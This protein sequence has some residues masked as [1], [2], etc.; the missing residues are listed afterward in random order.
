MLKQLLLPLAAVAGFIVL[1]GLM[2]QGKINLGG[3]ANTATPA[4]KETIKIGDTQIKVDIADT[5]EE[6]AKGLGGI[7]SLA[8]DEGM[9]FV[10]DKKDTTPSFW[11][12]DMLIPLDIIWIND[13]K[14]VRIDKNIPNSDQTKL[15]NPGTPIDYV[16]EV[17]A[18]FSDKKGLKVGDSAEGDSIKN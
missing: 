8:E 12:K 7:T 17:N 1:V 5:N 9:L 16:I 4:P 18:G 2:S 10:F 11:M 15:Y 3:L 14:V 13:S 6:R